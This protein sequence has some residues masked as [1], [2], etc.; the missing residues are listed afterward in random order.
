LGKLVN[1]LSEERIDLIPKGFLLVNRDGKILDFGYWDEVKKELYREVKRIDYGD[2]FILPGFI[3]AHLHLP[4]IDVRGKIMEGLLPWLERYV[5]PSEAKFEDADFAEEVARRFFSEIFR[6]GITTAVIYTTIHK[7]STD[8]VFKIAAEE[9]ARAI[10]GKVMM[11]RNS[12]SYLREDLDKSLNESISLFEK[13]NGYDGRLYYVFTPRFAVTS[14]I[15]L[16]REVGRCAKKLDAYIQTHLSENRDEVRFV[17]QNFEGIGSYTE[18]YEKTD[19]LGSKTLLAHAIHLNDEEYEILRRTDTRVI[20]CPSSNFFLHSG[21]MNLPMMEER[22]IKIALGSDVGAGPSFSPFYVMRDMF[23]ANIVSP[24]KAFY[25]ATL[26][27]AKVLGMEDKI[28]NFEVGK[29][30][31]FVVINPEPIASKG[32]SFEEVLSRLIFLGDDRV[33]EAT[34]IRGIRV[35]A[36]NS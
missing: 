5:Y 31:D 34:Y 7:E 19:L 12:P 22:G 23:Y 18:L 35:Y 21:I 6:N 20:H 11:D 28:G 26:G 9:K 16:L 1:V 24:F 33:T 25:Y 17:L 14:S 32:N 4:Q 8:R 27:G 29:E 13:W 15:E 10:I 30:A 2:F 3:D 36:K